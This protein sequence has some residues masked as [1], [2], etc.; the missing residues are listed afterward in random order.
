MPMTEAE[1]AQVRFYLLGPL[2]IE[3]G[4]RQICSD[5]WKSKKALTLLKYLITRPGERV[6]RD[7]LV[8]LLW[9]E[10]A[11]GESTY[12]K[13]YSTIYLL[14]KTIEPSIGD[15]NTSLIRYANNAY[16]FEKGQRCWLDTEEFERLYQQGDR[17]SGENPGAALECFE[18]ALSLYRGDF[19]SE[20]VYEDWTCVM[21]EHFKELHLN[22]VLKSSYLIVEERK[23]YSRALEMCTAALREN[24][25]REELYAAIISHLIAAN[26]YAEAA[27]QY[28]QYARMMDEEFGLDPSPDIRMLFDRIKKSMVVKPGA[29]TRPVESDSNPGAYV[30]DEETFRSIYELE[31]RRQDR[32]EEPITLISIVP[33]HEEFGREETEEIVRI[34][35]GAL[36][37][38]DVVCPLTPDTI[39]VLLPHTG[40]EGAQ[41]VVR[42]LERL[43]DNHPV[44]PVSVDYDVVEAS[45]QV[46]SLD[47]RV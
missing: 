5:D 27:A 24:P 1:K 43:L 33:D 29:R 17:L 2:R 47:A 40:D 10:S 4:E 32:R 9:R 42:R 8:E 39:V 25:F 12:H 45:D 28:R 15:A 46:R 30:C 18:R 19:L 34:L 23:G 13:L 3:M 14:R 26:R 6:P 11:I 7:V 38:G 37:R 21:R 36:R 16:W 41:V 20:D 35:S 44:D 22:T 31:L